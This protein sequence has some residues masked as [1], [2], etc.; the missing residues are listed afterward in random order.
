MKARQTQSPI[1]LY[2]SIL[3]VLVVT[4]TPGNGKIAGNYLDKVAHLLIFLFMTLNF[5]L[6]YKADTLHTEILF[7]LIISG[8]ATE[9]L[10]QFIPGRNMDLFD[11]L[12]DTV[13]VGVAYY[14]HKSKKDQINTFFQKMVGYRK[15]RF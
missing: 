15:K 14:F 13:G 11:A 1:L 6:Y 12:A 3:I 9:I 10:Q 8:F 5:L 4:L 7:W 2:L